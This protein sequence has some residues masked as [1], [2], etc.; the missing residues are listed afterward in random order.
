MWHSFGRVWWI[1][2]ASFGGLIFVVSAI[3]NGTDVVCLFGGLIYFSSAYSVS[4]SVV[5]SCLFYGNDLV[6][7]SQ[8]AHRL[9]VGS[10][11]EN[12]RA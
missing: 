6:L 1:D 3:V 8:F 5:P 2:L 11:G 10:E 4:L 7:F 12:L 9:G